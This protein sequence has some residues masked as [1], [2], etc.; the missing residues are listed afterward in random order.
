ME[1]IQQMQRT[2]MFQQGTNR[3]ETVQKRTSE[4][5]I[6]DIQSNMIQQRDH[7]NRI[8]SLCQNKIYSLEKEVNQLREVLAKT[9]EK[10]EK[11]NDKEVVQR[12]REALFNRQEK[13]PA[14][15]PIDRTGVAP[16]DVQLSKIFN[17]SGKK[18]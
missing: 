5:K 8:L 2:A 11:I 9:T 7:T 6:E 14:D 16:K 1:Y 4:E 13:I 12:S 17:F 3:F 18:F 15:M 10:L